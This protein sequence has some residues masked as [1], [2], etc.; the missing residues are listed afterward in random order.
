L[1]IVIVS[2]L[3]AIITFFSLI[4]LPANITNRT[5]SPNLIMRYG[6][7]DNELE[8]LKVVEDRFQGKYELLGSDSFY[9][10][11]IQSDVKWYYPKRTKVAS[12]DENIMSGDFSTCKCDIILLRE[13]TYKEP[14]GFGNGAIYKIEYN[15]IEVAKRQGY[16]EVWSNGEI[17]CL[18]RK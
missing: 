17:S 7:T 16:D 14:Y 3:V 12:L 4:G 6:L 8:G 13:A 1:K 10:S 2:L 15:P 18:V 11:Y 5:L 9:I